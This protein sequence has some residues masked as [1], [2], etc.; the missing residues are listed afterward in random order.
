MRTASCVGMHYDCLAKTADVMEVKEPNLE[1]IAGGAW[2][3]ADQTSPQTAIC[4][5]SIFVFQLVR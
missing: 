5:F 1:P 2:R 3:P 4:D